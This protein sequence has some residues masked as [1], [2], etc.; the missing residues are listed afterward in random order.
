MRDSSKCPSKNSTEKDMWLTKKQQQ[1]GRGDGRQ[2][3]W[4]GKSRSWW[5]WTDGGKGKQVLRSTVAPLIPGRLGH[6]P[7][8]GRVHTPGLI[9]C[10]HPKWPRHPKKSGPSLPASGLHL[11][12]GDHVHALTELQRA[13]EQVRKCIQISINYY[14]SKESAQ[15]RHWKYQPS[16]V[17]PALREAE[18]SRPTEACLVFYTPISQRRRRDILSPRSCVGDASN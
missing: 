3:I 8:L 17:V 16:G 4:T 15:M 12:H 9:C 1:K 18:W 11:H 6:C 14:M 10:H 2:E 5:Q 13:S 7:Q